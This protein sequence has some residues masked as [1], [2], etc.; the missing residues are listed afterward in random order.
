LRWMPLEA[1]GGRRLAQA[2]PGRCE[3]ASM[4]P[5]IFAWKPRKID[6]IP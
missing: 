5:P 2:R 6:E 3:P 1:A 4:R